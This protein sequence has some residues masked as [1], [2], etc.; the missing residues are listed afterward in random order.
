MAT[1]GELWTQIAN[2]V[3]LIDETWKIGSVNTSNFAS[4]Q[5]TLEQSFE[6]AHINNT[7]AAIQT[8]RNNLNS[9]V[10]S[11]SQAVLNSLLIELAR[12]GYDSV[13]TGA[14]AALEAIA[15]GMGLDSRIGPRFLNAGIGY[16]GSCFPKDVAALYRTSTDQAY[17]FKLIRSVMD[18][19]KSQHIHFLNKV[20]KFFGTNLTDK[21]FGVLGLA[22]K[23][24]TDDVR[25]SV[26]I[27][28]IRKL[29]GYGAVLKVYDPQGLYNE[30]KQL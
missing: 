9:A 7:A 10:F 24:N 25:A 16:G 15:K 18:V 11:Q 23:D 26:S 22:F 19:N 1:K 20:T 3:K 30:L 12:D 17:D 27:D 8:L 28:V 6:G 14:Q 4:L 21:T 13:V 5:D 2:A 29:R